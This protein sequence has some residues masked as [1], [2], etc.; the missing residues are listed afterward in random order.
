MHKNI[1]KRTIITII[2]LSPAIAW[3]FYKPVRVFAPEFISGITCKSTVIC[4]DDTSRYSEAVKLY[5]EA[6]EF[7]TSSIGLI[8]QKPRMIFCS[9]ESCFKSFGFNESSAIT[10]GTSGIVISPRGWKYYYIRHEIIHHLQTEKM[11]VISQWRSPEWF[12]EGMAY[13]LSK[14][15]RAKLSF[16]LEKYR[17]RFNAWYKNIDAEN[18]WELSHNL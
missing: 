16:K 5:N 9:T 8:K 7:V 15:P 17:T 3:S 4:L 6:I 11:G 12:K 13:S 10:V 1:T 2:L 18:I 14:D